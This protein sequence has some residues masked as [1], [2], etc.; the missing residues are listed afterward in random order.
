MVE[1]FSSTVPASTRAQTLTPQ[2]R[3][4]PWSKVRRETSGGNP[5]FPR[6]RVKAQTVVGL[7]ALGSIS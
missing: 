6:P 1:F 3:R 7:G 5:I 2:V 4:S